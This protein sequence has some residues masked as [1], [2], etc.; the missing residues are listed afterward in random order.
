[1][2]TSFRCEIF[3]VDLDATV[4]FYTEVLG[5]ELR[6]DRRSSG[7]PYVALVRG[8]IYLGAVKSSA[9]VDPLSRQPPAGVEL[10]LVTDHLEEDRVLVRE[11]G[12]TVVEDLA[13]QEWGLRDFRLLDPSGYY[14]R[15]TESGNSA[16]TALFV[17]DV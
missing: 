10:V 15:I 3:P 13:L 14:W 8:T 2:T 17:A 7:Q 5:F 11:A 6:I 16:E 12:W 1:M 9:S 4:G